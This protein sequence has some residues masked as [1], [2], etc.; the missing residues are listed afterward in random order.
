MRTWRAG[1][2][3]HNATLRDLATTG[4]GLLALYETDFDHQWFQEAL[5]ISESILEHFQDTD[6]GFY[7]TRAD[8]TDLITRPKS[9][10]DTPFPSGNSLALQLLLQMYNFTGDGRYADPVDR[11]LRGMQSA[12]SRYPSAFAGWLIA[13]DSAIGPRYQLALIGNSDDDRRKEFLDLVNTRYLPFLTRAAGLPSD[14]GG[15]ELLQ[16][17]SKIGEHVTAYLCQGFVCNTPTDSVEKFA[18]QLNAIL[19]VKTTESA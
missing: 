2:L 18:D 10:Q 11:A 7:D 1:T 16:G 6:G 19:T 5:Q 14:P 8:Q 9:V 3:K 15:P 12:A 17:R 4:L 13:L